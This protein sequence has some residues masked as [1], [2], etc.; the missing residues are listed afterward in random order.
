MVRGL[1]MSISVIIGLLLV[2]AVAC[3]ETAT[4]ASQPISVVEPE[5][6]EP[7]MV[8]V[9]ARVERVE[10][11]ISKSVPPEYS[12]TVVSVLNSTS[13]SRFEGYEVTRSESTVSVTVT[14][15]EVAPG[16]LVPC[17]DDLGFVETEI[18]L[19]SG[20]MTGESYTVVVNGEVTESF[21]AK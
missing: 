21:V 5:P 13:C 14:N 8:E 18:A 12:L 6:A 11:S 2:A 19:G 3:G 17:T 10:V 20:F 7:T 1:G 16:Q 9:P 15:L 4:P